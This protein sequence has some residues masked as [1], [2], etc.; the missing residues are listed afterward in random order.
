MTEK[1]IVRYY[2]FSFSNFIAAFGGGMILGKGLHV[3]HTKFLHGGSILA[4]FVGSLLGLIFLH[5][6]P[7]RLS[8]SMARWF[9]IYGAIMSLFLII[10]VEKYAI[11][12]QLFGMMAL[13]FFILLAIR[14]AF[15]FYSRVLRAAAVAGEEQRIAWVELG[16]YLG[17]ILGLIIWKFFNITLSIVVA[18]IIDSLLQLSAGLLDLLTNQLLTF[19]KKNQATDS[20]LTQ[21]QNIDKS[22]FRGWRLSISIIF[23][24]IGIQVI[25]F[26]LAHH[27]QSSFGSFILATFY[28]GVAISAL[29][30]KQ[31]SMHLKWFVNN[32][33]WQ[34][35]VIMI[36][37][38][39]QKIKI[40]IVI[41]TV[42]S[43]FFISLATIGI[44]DNLF[45]YIIQWLLLILIGVSAFFYE[46][47][48]LA[49]LDRIGLEQRYS[50]TKNR[51]IY[52]YGLMGVG[53]AVTLWMLGIVGSHL[54]ELFIVLIICIVAS[55][56]SLFRRKIPYSLSNTDRSKLQFLD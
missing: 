43:A 16:Y 56:L 29:I 8:R 17:I 14:F 15:W 11:N 46:L 9:S 44:Y 6:I 23:L 7:D 26:E 18:L 31:F 1:K 13:L 4:F 40:Q 53:A 25:I 22:D 30:Y 33:Y 49:I 34:Y 20:I 54:S 35:P 47:V 2:L 32:Q 12:G 37:L 36:K 5:L 27:I 39:N 45:G 51:I 24:T 41:V 3:I 10:V 42:I 38:N 21:T 28:F 50:E 55:I 52:T 19:S 48:A